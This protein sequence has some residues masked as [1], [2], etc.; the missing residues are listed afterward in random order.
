MF[1]FINWEET[2]EAANKGPVQAA[3]AVTLL[4]VLF[5]GGIAF[6]TTVL[7]G[8]REAP[9]QMQYDYEWFHRKHSRIQSLAVQISTAQA[10]ADSFSDTAGERSNWPR[11]DRAEHGRLT[12][13]VLGLRQQRAE[14]VGDYNSKSNMATRGIFRGGSLPPHID[15]EGNGQ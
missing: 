7:R 14:L 10:A 2:D 8:V 15:L 12:A 11:E 3:L 5:G 13:V 1:R 9:G 6:A 4:L